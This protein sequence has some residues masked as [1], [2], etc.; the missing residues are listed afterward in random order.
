MLKV[1]ESGV[2]TV[3]RVAVGVSTLISLSLVFTWYLTW[4]TR[5]R[6]TY[7]FKIKHALNI[8]CATISLVPWCAASIHLKFIV[9][10]LIS[11]IFGL[12]Q[13]DDEKRR[14]SRRKRAERKSFK[15]EKKRRKT[16]WNSTIEICT[17]LQIILIISGC[18][19]ESSSAHHSTVQ[20]DLLA[21][22]SQIQSVFVKCSGPSKTS[23]KQN[24]YDLLKSHSE[25]ERERAS[26]ICQSQDFRRWCGAVFIIDVIRAFQPCEIISIIL[27]GFVVRGKRT[28]VYKTEIVIDPFTERMSLNVVEISILTAFTKYDCSHSIGNSSSA[29]VQKPSSITFHISHSDYPS[30]PLLSHISVTFGWR[31][32]SRPRVKSNSKRNKLNHPWLLR[33]THNQVLKSN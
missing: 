12:S 29:N 21:N 16:A 27:L 22:S 10:N 23:L 9:V 4:M 6:K 20:N 2:A 28:K 19:I 13:S 33:A 18:W 26:V 31:L 15:G 1:T 3:G 11:L 25:R 14:R 17:E 7:G 8:K 24:I 30:P 5:E 32:W